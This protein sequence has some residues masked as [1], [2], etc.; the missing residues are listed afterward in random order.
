MPS[1]HSKLFMAI[2][3]APDNS[4]KRSLEW[5]T[6]LVCDQISETLVGKDADETLL[7]KDALFVAEMDKFLLHDRPMLKPD[8]LIRHQNWFKAHSI[9]G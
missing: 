8:Q 2:R 6:K 7:E 1:K 9:L 3:D 5:L 4:I